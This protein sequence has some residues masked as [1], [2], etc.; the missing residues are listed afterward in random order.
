MAM[1]PEAKVREL[2]YR[3]R[4]IQVLHPIVAE[5]YDAPEFE[6][7]FWECLTHDLHIIRQR[8]QDLADGEITAN[9]KAFRILMEGKDDGTAAIELYV[10]EIIGLEAVSENAKAQ[11][12][13]TA[14]QTRD[15]I[16]S[17][18]SCQEVSADMNKRVC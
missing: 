4:P 2:I 6:R 12:L 9:Q 16:L 11:T 14:L 5:M 15:Y 3:Y 18:R 7:M 8:S 17:R 1:S 13:A 10:N